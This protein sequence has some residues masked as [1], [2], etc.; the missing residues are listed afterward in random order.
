MAERTPRAPL[1]PTQDVF[2]KLRALARDFHFPVLLVYGRPDLPATDERMQYDNL[3]Y[4]QGMM[5]ILFRPGDGVS[6][7][8]HFNAFDG[9]SMRTV[10]VQLVPGEV[11]ENGPLH[12]FV[13]AGHASLRRG[14]V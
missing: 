11:G 9:E 6:T 14:G 7:R 4:S 12:P 5:A 10:V 3:Q 13:M 8:V 1:H 2:A